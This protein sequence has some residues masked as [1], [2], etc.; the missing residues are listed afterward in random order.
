MKKVI[1]L[2]AVILALASCTKKQDPFEWS[3]NRVG[4]LT[5]DMKV[6]QLDSIYANDS[7]VRAVKGDEF[8]NGA[9]LIEIFEKGGAHLLTLTPNQALDSTATIENIIIRDERF[10]TIK[11]ITKSSSFKDINAA[12]KINSVDNMIDDAVI[13]VNDENFYFSISKD[14]LPTDVK[15]DINAS[16]EKTMIPDDTKPQY[17]FV[18][19]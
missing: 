14:K 8:S 18:S 6:Y 19:W 12:Y 13:W 15:F 10:T 11:G 7:I 16:I 1:A 3:K 5:S 2:I 9:N 17:L 4:H